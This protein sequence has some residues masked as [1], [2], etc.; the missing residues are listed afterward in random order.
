MKKAN[1]KGSSTGLED[2]DPLAHCRK[3]WDF[4]TSF[5]FSKKS[6][7]LAHKIYIPKNK[8]NK[9]QSKI[10]RLSLPWKILL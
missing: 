5:S 10:L 9:R 7:Y 1:T 2:H 8:R 3:K 4:L 6:T